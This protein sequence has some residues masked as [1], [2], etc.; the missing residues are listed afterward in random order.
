MKKPFAKNFENT[1][2]IM[3]LKYIALYIRI[4]VTG[5]MK[6]LHI[7][8]QIFN[9]TKFIVSLKKLKLASIILAQRNQKLAEIS[10]FTAFLRL[11]INTRT[12]GDFAEPVTYA[13]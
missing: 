7:R 10:G 4:I 5:S 12:W 6:T 9:F 13:W 11:C 3:S 1:V 8:V 2:S